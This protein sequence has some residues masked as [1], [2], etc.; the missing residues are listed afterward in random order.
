MD[1]ATLSVSQIFSSFSFD[2][3]GAGRVLKP[4]V[5]KLFTFCTKSTK[6][7]P[8]AFIMH[9]SQ[10]NGFFRINKQLCHGEKLIKGKQ[11][12]W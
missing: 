1:L 3:L 11:S 8:A 4:I 5:L 12:R 6:I 9:V 7:I 2:L 10:G